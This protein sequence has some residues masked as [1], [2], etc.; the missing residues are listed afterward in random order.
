M[1]SCADGVFDN[2]F[3]IKHKSELRKKEPVQN[4]AAG[5]TPISV[6]Q[7]IPKD[8]EM[9]EID[10]QS[11]IGRFGWPV[12][13]NDVF[14]GVPYILRNSTKYFSVQMILK[15]R[16]I[17]GTYISLMQSTVYDYYYRVM[18]N[19]TSTE[20]KLLTEINEK[21][22]NSKFSDKTFT[23]DSKLLKDTDAYEFHDFL[24]TCFGKLRFTNKVESKIG[25]IQFN[26]SNIYIP[27][28]TIN[29]ERYMPLY[30]FSN[31]N[32]VKIDFISGWDLA[33]LRFC[34]LY[35][36]IWRGSSD[37]FA[38]VSLSSM[39]ANLPGSTS[40]VT[41]WPTSLDHDLLRGALSITLS[42]NPPVIFFF[43]NFNVK[44]V[45]SFVQLN[46]GTSDLWCN[47]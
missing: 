39:I 18:V 7:N 3:Y 32:S 47:I 36:G 17:I 14:Y 5:V 6:P 37:I 16:P 31:S 21:H 1:D 25:F 9:V 10:H 46:T 45:H 43:L 34:C 22:C 20:C 33:Y 23:V 38:V 11:R 41:C 2:N 26:F 4:V 13:D 24:E 29:K 12:A 35:Q 40:F 8:E 42:G 44:Q 30:C 28:V 15:R 27:F 19:A